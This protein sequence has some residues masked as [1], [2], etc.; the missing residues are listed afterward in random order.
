[1]RGPDGLT[2]GGPECRDSRETARGLL[3]EVK[4]RNRSPRPVRPV[5]KIKI[6]PCLRCRK[7][8]PDHPRQ[9]VRCRSCSLVN[10]EAL[11]ERY[12]TLDPSVLRLERWLKG[13]LAI[14]AAMALVATWDDPKRFPLTVVFIVLTWFTLSKLSKRCDWFPPVEVWSLT[15]GGLAGSLATHQIWIFAFSLVLATAFL[16]IFGHFAKRWKHGKLVTVRE[17]R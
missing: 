6:R 9:F 17:P 2:I 14:A 5:R 1:M 16:P 4:T 8:L 7:R 3:A 13:L 12:W 10:T 11:R 15:F